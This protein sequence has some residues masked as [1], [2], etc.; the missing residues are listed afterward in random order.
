MQVD[1]RKNNVT[2]A[3]ALLNKKL[4]EDGDLRRYREKQHYEKKAV[5]RQRRLKEAQK[6][7]RKE[8]LTRVDGD[9][10][11]YKSK[12]RKKFAKDWEERVRKDAQ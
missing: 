12:K 5:A 6:R 8:L 11:V 10:P 1:V 4:K 7:H 3:W 9:I 2:K